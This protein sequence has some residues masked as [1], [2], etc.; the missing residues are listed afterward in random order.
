MREH[1]SRCGSRALELANVVHI[2]NLMACMELGR[3]LSHKVNPDAF[4][5]KA[6]KG[7]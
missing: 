4:L 1:A 3:T 7:S 2:K 6:T 5:H